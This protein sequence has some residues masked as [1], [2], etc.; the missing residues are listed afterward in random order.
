MT[1]RKPPG[2]SFQTWVDSQVRRA[3]EA[4]AFDDLAGAGRPLAGLDRELTSYDW[5]LEWARR[6]N[7][8]PLGMLPPGLALRREREDL[9]ARLARLPSETAVRAAVDN[10]NARVDAFWRRPAEGPPV[11]VGQVDVAAAVAAWRA[12]RPAPAEEAAPPAPTTRR[13][14]WRRRR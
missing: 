3:Q 9:P 1:E 2:V 7:V 13:R 5:A 4:G 14:W 10:F 12:A 6:E 11:P 8:D